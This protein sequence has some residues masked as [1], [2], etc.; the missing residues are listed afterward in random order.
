MA[1]DDRRIFQHK[2][3]Q[4]AP[5]KDEVEGYDAQYQCIGQAIII[6]LVQNYLASERAFYAG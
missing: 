2:F 4:I 5:Q 1:D 6:P 3:S